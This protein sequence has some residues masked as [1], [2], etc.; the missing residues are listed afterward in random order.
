MDSLY[1]QKEI[2]E[3]MALENEGGDIFFDG[4]YWSSSHD[5]ENTVW[6][7]GFQTGSQISELKV[8]PRYVRAIRE[9]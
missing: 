9:F 3:E 8:V 1:Q 6:V 7:Q 2:V 4:K 5:L